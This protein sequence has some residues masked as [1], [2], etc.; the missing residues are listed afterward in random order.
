MA[1]GSAEPISAPMVFPLVPCCGSV[2][3]GGS[4]S[5]GCLATGY[6]PDPVNITWNSGAITTVV[7]TPP[8]VYSS[9]RGTYMRSSQ[10]TVP[11]ARLRNGTYECSVEHEYTG[12]KQ[13]K[14]VKVLPCTEPLV[15]V[16][17][18]PPCDTVQPLTKFSNRT[19][20][21][22]ICLISNFY[23]SYIRVQWLAN[24][25]PISAQTTP[26]ATK[27]DD[28][29]FSA[30]SQLTVNKGEYNRGTL[31]SCSITHPASGFSTLANISKCA[32][33]CPLN[34]GVYL[35]PP[36]FEDLYLTQSAHLVCLVTN[37][38]TTESFEILWAR[39]TQGPLK[40]STEDP[41]LHENGTYS[42]VS[43]LA[44]CADD[45]VSRE[46]FTCTIKHQDLPSPVKAE[47]VKRKDGSSRA[48]AVY[49][50]P[51]SPEELSVREVA[52]ITCFVKDFNPDEIFVKWLKNGK[53]V[54]TGSYITTE[55][56]QALAGGS[57][58]LYS[59]M[60]ADAA[61]WNE[62]ESFTCAVG[63]EALPMHLIQKSIDK[64]TD[65]TEILSEVHEY[66]EIEGDYKATA[67]TFMVLFL[68]SL[69]YSTTIT[70]F[71]VKS[72]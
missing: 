36:S 57:Y 6:M 49:L 65:F 8:S 4:V 14:T 50:L 52:T 35:L 34:M 40:V 27:G 54:S 21:E 59:S 23:P 1:R 55:P 28:G 17:L 56:T 51:P 68:L 15:K 58:F 33:P 5:L 61:E 9:S 71:K 46:K 32:E 44:I 63:H 11:A 69:F 3:S 67:A 30:S 39:S 24:G 26:V 25:K 2:G 72:N 41:Q 12:L 18:S 13:E 16:V 43:K 38:K 22:L 70:L 45:W 29:L 20:V 7:T 60:Q 64:F 37:M 48:P 53:E 66:S 19:E 42:V 62:G 10:I 47:I 31:Y